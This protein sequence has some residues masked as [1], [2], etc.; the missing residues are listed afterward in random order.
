M[1]W[2]RAKFWTGSVFTPQVPLIDFPPQFE[3]TRISP[4]IPWI[5]ERYC[6]LHY[7]TFVINRVVIATHVTDHNWD[8][9]PGAGL[10]ASVD[11]ELF[12]EGGEPFA[13]SCTWTN[14]LSIS[15]ANRILRPLNR[16]L[17]RFFFEV[18]LFWVR[19]RGDS[20]RTSNI[21][22]CTSIWLRTDCAV[23]DS[24]ITIVE[25]KATPV[26]IPQAKPKNPLACW[27]EY[28]IYVCKFICSCC[29]L[30]CWLLCWVLL[31]VWR[32]FPPR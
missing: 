25:A 22:R 20:A 12:G 18:R 21:W 32:V 27:E 9:N 1:A 16:S 26:M 7:R 14:F 13:N 17:N 23:S 8:A 19:C 10:L 24:W 5:L 4:K 28:D 30:L 3:Q 2:S 6:V 11:E 15:S 31:Y 29:S